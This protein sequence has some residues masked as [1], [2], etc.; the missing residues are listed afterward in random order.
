MQELGFFAFAFFW[1]V[2]FTADQDGGP[3]ALRTH[4]SVP[5]ML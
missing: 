4:Y 5:P 2:N 1:F 3:Q